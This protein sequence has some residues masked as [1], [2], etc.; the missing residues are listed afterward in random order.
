MP[1]KFT[2]KPQKQGCVGK[3]STR[4]SKNPTFW[5]R[6]LFPGIT[7]LLPL[8]FLATLF[9]FPLPPLAQPVFRILALLLSLYVLLSL[10]LR[11][12]RLLPVALGRLSAQLHRLAPAELR[13]QLTLLGGLLLNLAYSIFRTVM[14][15][16][17]HSLW[18]LAE[19]VY[20]MGLCATRFW[21]AQEEHLRTDRLQ[22][23][24]LYLRGGRFLLILSLSAAGTVTLSVREQ[25][26]TAYSDPLIAV[27]AAFAL[28]RVGAAALSL[29]RFRREQRPVPLLAKAVSLSAAAVSLF[30]LQSTL[31]SRYG[32]A[33]PLRT[34]WNAATG[35]FV[36]ISLPVLALFIF[37]KGRNMK[38]SR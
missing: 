29:L 17:T 38:N 30:G 14:G 13:A 2:N 12:P 7:R 25:R 20:Y 8:V 37:S 36:C 19:S 33:L 5:H 26:Y 18:F 11:L 23:A 34:R 28:W 27:T 21:I 32:V 10:G 6:L 15:V 3:N 4:P 9:F 1:K 22:R 24:E 35:C 16:M 31:L